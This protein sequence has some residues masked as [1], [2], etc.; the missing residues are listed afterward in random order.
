MVV[1]R[2]RR[3][4][5]RLGEP[6]VVEPLD[7]EPAGVAPKLQLHQHQPGDVQLRKG[8][9][10]RYTVKYGTEKVWMERLPQFVRRTRRREGHEG[11]RRRSQQECLAAPRAGR[12]LLR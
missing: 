6:S 5:P 10:E 1:L 4:Q 12:V 11:T 2:E 3:R 7:E 9:G 8:H